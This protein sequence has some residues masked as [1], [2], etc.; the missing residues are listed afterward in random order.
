VQASRDSARWC[1]VAWPT[2]MSDDLNRARSAPGMSVV[3]AREVRLVLPV[4]GAMLARLAAER[5]RTMT[6]A[7]ERSEPAGLQRVFQ[8]WLRQQGTFRLPN[9]S[10]WS[11]LVSESRRT[12][13]SAVVQLDSPPQVCGFQLSHPGTTRIAAVRSGSVRSAQ[14]WRE[15][16]C[17]R[18]WGPG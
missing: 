3:A 15:Q 13:T 4:P 5:A 17:L 11:E 12:M 16:V 18:D 2:T 10:G 14:L 1:W 9:G 7:V 6:S 8:A